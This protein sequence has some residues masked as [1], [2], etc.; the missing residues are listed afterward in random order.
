MR[1]SRGTWETLGGTSGLGGVCKDRN[2]RRGGSAALATWTFTPRAPQARASCEQQRDTIWDR[3]RSVSQRWLGRVGAGAGADDG[4]GRET[5]EDPAAPAPAE[6]PWRPDPRRRGRRAGSSIP[7]RSEGWS[8]WGVLP[9]P[10]KVGSE[11]PSQVVFC[12]LLLNIWENG[13]GEVG[14]REQVAAG[15]EGQR[16][17]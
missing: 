8:P 7:D 3:I 10:R 2:G 1:P 14:W 5:Q 13:G 4:G 11:G 12:F 6:F 16:L 9:L 15:K 17:V